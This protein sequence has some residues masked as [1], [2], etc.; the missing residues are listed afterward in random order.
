[1]GDFVASQGYKS[2][3][4]V[5][6]KQKKHWPGT[7]QYAKQ[8]KAEQRKA[9]RK[10]R[11][12][13][14]RPPGRPRKPREEEPAEI[15][16]EPELRPFQR[17]G[18]DFLAEHNWRVLLADAPGLG[19]T[20]QV[21]TAI[22]ENARS[23]CPALAVVPASIVRNWR[24]EALRW[25]PGMRVQI[26]ANLSSPIQ[27]GHHLTIT[28]WDML[29]LRQAELSRYGFRLIV[30]DE[31]HYAKNPDAQRSQALRAIAEVAPHLLLLSGTPLVNDVDELEILRSLFGSEDPPMLR[32][33]LE[34]AA[35]DIPPKRRVVLHADIPDEI[36]HEYNEVVEIYS[37]WLQEY[38]PKILESDADIEAAAERATSMPGLS[39]LSYLRRIIGRGKVP[40]AAAWVLEQSRKGEPVVI[41]GQ[42]VDVLDLLGQ[43]LSR[44]GLPYVR[45]DGTTTIEQRQAA[46]D[47]FQNGK[48]NVFIGSQA[49]REGITLTRAANLLFLERW[50]TPASEEQAEDRIRR[51]TQTRPTTIWYLHAEGT[52]DDRI[53][54]IVERKRTL[55]AK[56][57]GSA[58][59]ATTEHSSVMDIWRRVR[60]LARGVDRVSHNPRA[61]IDLPPLPDNGKSVWAVVF[62]ARA[63]P[64]DA[65]QRYLRKNKYRCRKI[66]RSG[67]TVRIQ[68]RAKT[69]FEANTTRQITMAPGY[70][71]VVGK[72]LDADAAARMR[73][74]RAE[75]KRQ[76]VR[77]LTPRAVKPRVIRPKIAKPPRK[78]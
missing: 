38:L 60:E 55:V 78:K 21:L 27:R 26:A 36:R 29:A 12:A 48:I 3:I 1:V 75:R 65:L 41:F 61:Q 69:A 16:P 13:A 9:R 51:I 63:W 52:L 19:K 46:V 50:W 74:V 25:V 8:R 2:T 53:N 59:I 76:G 42:Y 34:D 56:H 28:T 49:A 18:V 17:E 62:D 20:G 45:I 14:R 66:E 67:T 47:A 70:A 73:R 30:A 10:A 71:I 23:L 68:V 22:K 5:K 37:E 24:R 64:I 58:T 77:R 15:G 40:A 57:I 33:L 31:A 4:K 44:L 11:D 32:R 43:S 54:E 72:P 7:E 6:L 39:K 35:P